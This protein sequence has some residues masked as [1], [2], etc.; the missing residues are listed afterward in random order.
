MTAEGRLARGK[1]NYEAGVFLDNQETID[2]VD[3]L[4]KKEEKVAE[5]APK[6]QPEASEEGDDSIKKTKSKEKK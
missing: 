3:T 2:Y 4:P 1:A 6:E 5:D